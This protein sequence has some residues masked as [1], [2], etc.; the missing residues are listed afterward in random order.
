M[1]VLGFYRV[2]YDYANWNALIDQ[3]H[4][5]ANAIHVLNRAQLIDDAF[6]LAKANRV[7]YALALNLTRYLVQE[8]DVI[9]WHTAKREFAFLMNRMRRC[10]HGYRDLKVIIILGKRA[11]SRGFSRRIK[12][13]FLRCTSVVWPT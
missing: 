6:N 4:A 13:R 5:D 11:E 10:S 2:N 9:P 1:G 3:L 12:I 7:P 8:D